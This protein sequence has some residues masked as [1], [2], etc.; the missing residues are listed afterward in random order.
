MLLWTRRNIYKFIAIATIPTI[1][2]V[3]FD[4]KFIHLPWLPIALV[5]SILSDHSCY[6]IFK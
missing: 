1:L 3:V 2:Y 5:G 4:W 6:M